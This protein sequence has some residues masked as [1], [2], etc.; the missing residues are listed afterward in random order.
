MKKSMWS[1]TGKR[2]RG[3]PLG[4]RKK[5]GL[6]KSV[7]TR[8][9]TQMWMW[10]AAQARKADVNGSDIVRQVIEDRMTSDKPRKT[11]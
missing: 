1:A 6:S 7:M 3:R 2:P 8:M 9:S 4:W 10:I 5:E 11:R